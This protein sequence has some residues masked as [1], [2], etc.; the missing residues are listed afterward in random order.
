M[1][2]PGYKRIQKCWILVVKRFN[3]VLVP[4]G[5]ADPLAQ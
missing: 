4:R 3:W 5:F 1:F 2:C